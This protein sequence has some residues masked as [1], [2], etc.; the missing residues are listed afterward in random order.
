MTQSFDNFEAIE[1]ESF[2]NFDTDFNYMD[3][4]AGKSS[5]ISPETTQQ[6]AQLGTQLIG[7]VVQSKAAQNASMPEFEVG[8]KSQCGNKPKFGGIRKNKSREY[9]SCKQRYTTDYNTR[10]ATTRAT[11]EASAL[12]ATAATAS[13]AGASAGG[14]GMS[15]TMKIGIGVG[16]L[17]L[18]AGIVYMVKK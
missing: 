1:A 15:S 5:A 10:A 6:L 18:L 8:L 11:A 13:G 12:A 2:S 16:A 17:V 9:D 4:P 3:A 7:R 14:S